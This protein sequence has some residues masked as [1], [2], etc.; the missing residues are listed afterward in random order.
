M[1]LKNKTKNS[2]NPLKRRNCISHTH[3]HTRTHAR[4]Q[5]RT[6]RMVPFAYQVSV[7]RPIVKVS[8]VVSLVHDVS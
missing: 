5:A 2:Y 6:H 3:T 7:I 8:F 4:T 1:E